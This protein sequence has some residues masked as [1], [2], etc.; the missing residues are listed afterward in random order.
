MEYCP[1]CGR[2]HTGICGIP[3]YPRVNG[4]PTVGHREVMLESGS[5]SST[6]SRRR[7]TDFV[8]HTK[9]RT[10]QRTY[11]KMNNSLEKLLNWGKEEERKC[12]E[13]L[14]ILPPEVEEYQEVMEK[15]DK[16][17]IAVKQIKVRMG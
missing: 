16:L 1:R 13:L 2:R 11:H 10:Y 15:L 14:K 6:A 7:G 5:R 12:L 9:E 3:G 17:Q 8:I 4:I